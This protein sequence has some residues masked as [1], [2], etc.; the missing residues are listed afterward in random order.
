MRYNLTCCLPSSPVKSVGEA[1][2]TPLHMKSRKKALMVVM[3]TDCSYSSLWAVF[4]GLCH[5]S[6]ISLFVFPQDNSMRK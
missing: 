1:L 5:I 3:M 4:Q 6:T 2:M